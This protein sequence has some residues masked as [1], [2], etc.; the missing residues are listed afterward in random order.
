MLQSEQ[1]F[2]TLADAIP[3]LCWM[4]NAD[5]WLFW[6]NQR[7][8]EFTGTTPEQM[9]GWGWQSVHDPEVLPQVLEQWKVAIA[10]T[11]FVVGA[12]PKMWGQRAGFGGSARQVRAVNDPGLN[13]P[14]AA[15]NRPGVD[16]GLNQPGAAGNRPGVDP[17]LNQPGAAGNRG[18]VDP[19]RNQP[20]AAGN[21][22]R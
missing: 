18:G 17:G 19:G 2:R 12:S 4:A 8:Y 11:I 6:Y 7:W 13:Q 1:Q 9:E 10:T 20:G 14:G 21:R 16:P 5:G 15:G 3:Q 22:R